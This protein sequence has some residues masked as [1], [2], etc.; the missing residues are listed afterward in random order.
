MKTQ[1]TKKVMLKSRIVQISSVN[2]NFLHMNF[3]SVWYN[4]VLLF[5]LISIMKSTFNILPDLRSPDAE[6]H[7]QPGDFAGPEGLDLVLCD[8]PVSL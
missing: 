5:N 7:D 3:P 1:G 6:H 2:I 8:T 4:N